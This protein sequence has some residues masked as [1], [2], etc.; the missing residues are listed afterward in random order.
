MS[1]PDFYVGIDVQVRRGLPYCILDQDAAMVASGWIEGVGAT[2]QAEA[3]R[4]ALRATTG[5]ARLAIGI[6]APRMPLPDVRQWY[7]EGAK[8]RWR[9]KRSTDKGCGRHCEVVVKA[10]GMANPQWTPLIGES[11]AWMRLGYVLFRVL[12]SLGKVYEVFPSASY[13]LLEDLN[14]ET[15]IEL[16]QF[17]LGPKDMLDAIVGAVTVREFACGHGWE[18]GGGDGLGTIILPGPP[19]TGHPCT[20]WPGSAC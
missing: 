14:V 3:M 8:K 1:A 18:A 5:G 19:P 15:K 7:W 12:E 13:S 9:A 16:S 20:R 6:D 11:P 10:L 17:R 4:D 2:E